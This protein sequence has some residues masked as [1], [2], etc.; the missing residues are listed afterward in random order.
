MDI[1]APGV[2]IVAVHESNPEKQEKVVSDARGRFKLS[3]LKKGR[4]EFRVQKKLT[5]SDAQKLPAHLAMEKGR[6]VRSVLD[7]VVEESSS[8]SF[9]LISDP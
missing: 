6:V 1:R 3:C 4:Y 8:F 2:E 7:Y 9:G 5:R